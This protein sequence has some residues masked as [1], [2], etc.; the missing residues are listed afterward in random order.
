LS[1]NDV[2]PSKRHEPPTPPCNLPSGAFYTFTA[3]LEITEGQSKGGTY[4]LIPYLSFWSGIATSVY[5]P[6]FSKI[7]KS[8]GKGP[9]GK[10]QPKCRFIRE[11]EACYSKGHRAFPEAYTCVLEVN[12][13]GGNAV[14]VQHD[15][16]L[17]SSRADGF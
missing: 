12:G 15:L 8:T 11:G 5:R 7:Q 13:H 2:L 9:R 3:S 1:V 4:I 17:S 10:F 16:S 14:D 6:V